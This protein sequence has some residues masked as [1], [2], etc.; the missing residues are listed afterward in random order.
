MDPV[1]GSP[2]AARFNPCDYPLCWTFPSRPCGRNPGA[3]IQHI[4]FAFA[5]VEMLRPRC[6]VELGVQAGDS[7]LAFCQAVKS[8]ELEARCYGVDHWQ[9]DSHT[10]AYGAGVLE[11]L[12]E[13]HEPHY[14]GFSQLLQSTFDEAVQQFPDGGIDL[15]HIDGWHTYEAVCHDFKTWQPKLSSRAVVLFHDTNVRTNDFGV[16]RLWQELSAAHPHFEFMHGSGLGVLVYGSEAPPAALA[17]AGVRGPDAEAVRSFYF[18]LG[19]R[20]SLA[21]DLDQLRDALMETREELAESREELARQQASLAL[22]RGSRVWRLR[23]FLY[24]LPACK[25]VAR[26]MTRGEKGR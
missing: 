4:P 8:L 5:L 16:W 22:I 18:A 14:A 12:R 7:F 13:Y 19:H 15:L 21:L 1:E 17:L 25:Q 26:C 10:G 2:Q 9:G 3:W 23:E 20:L 24:S 6:V 11:E